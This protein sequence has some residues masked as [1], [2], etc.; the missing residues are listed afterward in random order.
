MDPDTCKLIVCKPRKM[1]AAHGSA[2]EVAA[3]ILAEPDIGIGSRI[4][5]GDVSYPTSPSIG[6]QLGIAL[7]VRL[8]Q[9]PICIKDRLQLRIKRTRIFS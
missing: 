9:S 5:I 4:W 6:T 7:M 8:D 2:L 1:P 3:E